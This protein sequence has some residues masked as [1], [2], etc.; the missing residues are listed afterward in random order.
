MSAESVTAELSVYGLSTEEG[1]RRIRST[2][3]YND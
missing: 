2:G 1:W 3:Q